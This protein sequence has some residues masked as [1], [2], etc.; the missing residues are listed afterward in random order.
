[1]GMKKA[2]NI[3]FDMWGFPMP[4]DVFCASLRIQFEEL[5]MKQVLFI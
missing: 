1:M 4:T 2:Y 3:D 5:M